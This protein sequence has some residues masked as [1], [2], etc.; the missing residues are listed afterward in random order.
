MKSQKFSSKTKSPQWQRVLAFYLVFSIVNFASICFAQISSE[1]EP[2]TLGE[3]LA[4]LKESYFNQHKYSE[5]VDYLKNLKQDDP[6]PEVSYYIALSIPL[7]LIIPLL[8]QS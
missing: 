6:L 7:L 2:F 3:D 4:R 5:F 8:A 1:V